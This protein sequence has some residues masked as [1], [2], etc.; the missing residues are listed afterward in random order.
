MRR[1]LKYHL[2]FESLLKAL[3]ASDEPDL[4]AIKLCNTVI[5]QFKNLNNVINAA[6][7]INEI[8]NFVFV[9]IIYLQKVY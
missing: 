6:E 7:E 2:I 3:Q 8:N 1:I 9:S 4:K 5:K